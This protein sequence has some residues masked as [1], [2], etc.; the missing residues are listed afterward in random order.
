MYII[1]QHI[2]LL[3]HAYFI[4]IS[5][6]PYEYSIHVFHHFNLEM[7]CIVRMYNEHFTKT[8]KIK[9]HLLKK[10]A[11]GAARIGIFKKRV[12]NPPPPR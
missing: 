11:A 5:S 1:H 7:L 4:Q 3:F 6:Y 2:V 12:N 8:L 9:S 10:P